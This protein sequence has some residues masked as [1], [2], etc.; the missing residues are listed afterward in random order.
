MSKR[1]VLQGDRAVRPSVRKR[2]VG[3]EPGRHGQARRFPYPRGVLDGKEAHTLAGAESPVGIP[4][5]RGGAGGVWYAHNPTLHRRAKGD[6][7]EVCGWTQDP[8]GMPGS[9]PK[10]R[11]GAP[12]VVMGAEDVL[13]RRLIYLDLAIEPLCSSLEPSGHRGRIAGA[14]KIQ[15]GRALCGLLHLWTNPSGGTTRWAG[16]ESMW[17]L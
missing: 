8:C 12:A 14:R 10:A 17:R 7:C 5:L 1:Q 3:F 4:T 13:G 6:D 9:R 16:E 15:L 11:F 2:D